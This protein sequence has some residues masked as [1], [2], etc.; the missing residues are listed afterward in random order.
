MKIKILVLGLIVLFIFGCAMLR[1]HMLNYSISLIE[2]E[3]PMEAKERYGEQKI[4]Y[5]D[6]E[7]YSYAFEDEMIRI[8][9][10]PTSSK[11][12]FLLENKTDYSIRIIWDEAAYV[13]ENGQ[14]HRV[15]HSGVRYIE[16]DN[17]KPPSVVVRKG[18]LTDV[19]F[20]T[21]YVVSGSS[22]WEE[23]PILPD[24]QMGGDPQKLLGNAK[25]YIN[26]TIQILLP[27]QIE[28]FTN[29]YIFIFKINDVEYTGF[30]Q[31]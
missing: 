1:M 2:V 7:D 20:P 31:Y 24:S 25:K 13:D 15:M 6:E 27:I 12:A 28:E 3:R 10:L 22:G 18:K 26:K 9:W 30:K 23:T 21:D 11:M 5:I 8:L 4:T 19:I 16:R 17:P 14:S 29:D